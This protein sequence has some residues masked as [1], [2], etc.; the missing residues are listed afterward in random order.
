[1][2][3]VSAVPEYHNWPHSLA[4]VHSQAIIQNQQRYLDEGGKF[5]TCFPRTQLVTRDKPL[6][7]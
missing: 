3:V 4:W 7:T 5:V 1:M 6:Q 2:R